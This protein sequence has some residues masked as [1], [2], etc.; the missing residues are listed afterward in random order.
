[1]TLTSERSEMEMELIEDPEDPSVVNNQ[2]FV[3][4]QE[5]HLHKHVEAHVRVTTSAYK[6]SK[7]KHPALTLSC[8][9]TRRAK[10]FFWNIIVVMVSGTTNV[11]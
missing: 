11:T 1:M 7:H 3:D 5:W 10:Y 9:A 4:E 2:S 6:N 8:R